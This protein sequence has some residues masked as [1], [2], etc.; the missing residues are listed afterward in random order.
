M[1][2][3][4][5]KG[6]TL[7]ELMIVI[8][9]IGIMATAAVPTF[10]DAVIR[11]QVKEGIQLADSLKLHIMAYYQQHQAFPADNA[12]AHLAQ[13]EAF[14]GNYVTRI[15]IEQGA[16]H[17]HL[18]HRVNQHVKG[19]ILSVRP[20]Y[21][22]AHPTAPMSWVCGYAEPVPGMSVQGENKTTVPALYLSYACRA[23][24]ATVKQKAS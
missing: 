12:A 13:P 10:Q 17:I 24:A 11:G 18:G 9:I 6:F 20:A 15:E 3:M 2:T 7:I 23:W 21:V 19:K 1:L 16:L 22:T 4:K 14:I 8:A 5:K